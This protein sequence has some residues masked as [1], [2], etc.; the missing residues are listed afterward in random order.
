MR[1]RPSLN[2]VPGSKR[3]FQT[4]CSAF[5]AADLPVVR[6][7]N[8]TPATDTDLI[9]SRQALKRTPSTPWSHVILQELLFAASDTSAPK[10][11]L[12]LPTFSQSRE[13]IPPPPIC[14]TDY[15]DVDITLDI[16]CGALGHSICA[17]HQ[18]VS[19]SSRHRTHWSN[20]WSSNGPGICQLDAHYH[21]SN[22]SR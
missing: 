20:Y 21:G 22:W 6:N 4:P 19:P 16:L 15:P 10:R 18:L 11:W 13:T 3:R 17:D 14:P 5:P 2:G 7:V 1:C 12:R 9:V 8:V